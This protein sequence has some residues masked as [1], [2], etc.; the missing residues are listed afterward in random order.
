MKSYFFMTFRQRLCF[1]YTT[2]KAIIHESI[3]NRL[4]RFYRAA[5]VKALNA[6]GLKTI[7]LTRKSSMSTEELNH[8]V[9]GDLNDLA[10]LTPVFREELTV[11]YTQLHLATTTNKLLMV[12]E[13]L[14][15]SIRLRP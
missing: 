5:V 3:C 10:N 9:V 7:S 12:S 4:Y 1:V 11:S 2:E 15:N 14:K 6:Q 8:E 13:L